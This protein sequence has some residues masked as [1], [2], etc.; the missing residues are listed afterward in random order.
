M[1]RRSCCAQQFVEAGADEIQHL[2]FIVLN[3]FHR[4]EGHAQQGSL[5]RHWPSKL[6]ELNLESPEVARVHEL[7]G[8][9]PHGARSDRVRLQ[10]LFSGDP[11]ASRAGAA[12]HDRARFPPVTR[13]RLLSGARGR[14]ARQ[15]GGLREA[16]PAL[17][18]LLKR[19]TT[20]ASRI[21]PGTD[22]FAGYTPAPRARALRAGR[23]PGARSAAHGH[24]GP[25]AGGGRRGYERGV[26][27]PGKHADMI[28]VDGDP[29][30]RIARHPQGGS[31]HEGRQALR[32]GPYR[33]RARHR[34]ARQQLTS[35][36]REVMKYLHTMVRVTDLDASLHFYCDALGLTELSR[37]DNR[38]GPLHA[39]VPRRR[40][41]RARAGRADLQ[42]GPGGLR[43][44]A[45]L[46]PPRLRGGRHLRHLP[47]PA[48]H[49]VTINRPPRD[50]HMAF[51]RSPDN[52][53]I[54]LLQKGARAAAAEPWASMPNTGSW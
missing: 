23:H 40:R 14:A 41:R 27:A 49:G 3:F 22:A 10:D 36:R 39:G 30:V 35:T 47:A 53:S 15:G 44:R 12:R 45:Q 37:K 7:P 32:P 17:Q 11:A 20:A 24:A 42:L 50:G 46:R 54:E 34:P 29:S 2:N 33:A 4:G 9:A 43:R 16:L 48:E 28:L 18:R 26:I 25:G 13:R 5:H 51:V 21:M 6:H 52:I 1:C 31:R 19:C 38:E 8:A